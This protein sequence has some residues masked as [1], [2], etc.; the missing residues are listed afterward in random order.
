MESETD[1]GGLVLVPGRLDDI[2]VLID[3]NSKAILLVKRLSFRIHLKHKI[4]LQYTPE[5][6]YSIK[7]A[8]R[9]C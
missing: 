2:A 8:Q 5:I 7:C 4:Q 1:R 9:A 6:T 3:L